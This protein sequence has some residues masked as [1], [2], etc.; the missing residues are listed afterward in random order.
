[1][2]KD[3]IYITVIIFISFL[4]GCNSDYLLKKLDLN[5]TFYKDKLGRS[6][7]KIFNLEVTN[8]QLKK[9]AD[10]LKIET[11]N[12]QS[13][14]IINST[15]SI[16]GKQKTIT[17]HDTIYLDS[18]KEVIKEIVVT[19]SININTKWDKGYIKYSQNIIEYN[20][21]HYDSLI[22]SSYQDNAKSDIFTNVA[23]TNPN[24]K[25]LNIKQYSVRPKDQI[26]EVEPG[27]SAV[28]NVLD[29]KIAVGPSANLTVD[30]KEIKERRISKRL[31][32]QIL[33]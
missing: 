1:M 6:N 14:T 31:S 23:S 20:L 24:I 28:W 8:K 30:F 13:A 10:S 2:K 9:L 33:K 26:I 5:Q 25:S 4:G 17:I 16:K 18:T 19:D 29:R 22:I 3:I 7:A 32:K 11:E 12:I 21:T 27:V 15:T